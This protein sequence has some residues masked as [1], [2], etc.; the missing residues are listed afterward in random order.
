MIKRIVILLLAGALAVSFAGSVVT[1]DEGSAPDVSD[2]E[3][4]T[5]RIIANGDGTT[6]SC[7]MVA[8]KPS[9]ITKRKV[10]YRG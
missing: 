4:Y 8:E 10:Q 1:A 9:E 6:E 5:V 2:R 3:P 7:E